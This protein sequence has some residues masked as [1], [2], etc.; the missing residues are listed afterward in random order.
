[1]FRRLGYLGTGRS[2]E[3]FLLFNPIECVGVGGKS[4]IQFRVPILVPD[5]VV[6]EIIPRHL[7]KLL[8]GYCIISLPRPRHVVL[9]RMIGSLEQISSFELETDKCTD[10]SCLIKKSDSACAFYILSQSKFHPDVIC[11]F[12][13]STLIVKSGL[14]VTLVSCIL[15]LFLSVEILMAFVICH[16]YERIPMR[17]YSI[18]S[19]PL[20][21]GIEVNLPSSTQVSPP[22][23]DDL[24]E[25]NYP[26][27]EP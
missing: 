3:E 12:C 7:N 14:S 4:Y 17:Q 13:D 26:T 23:Y 25:E 11:D 22:H 24:F 16:L 6:Y 21:S 20:E 9:V 19:I 27:L 5:A 10:T 15:V 2:T 8:Q 1:M 18:S